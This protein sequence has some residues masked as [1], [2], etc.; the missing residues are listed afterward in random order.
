MNVCANSIQANQLF[1]ENENALIFYCA[2]ATQATRLLKENGLL[3][4]EIQFEVNLIVF[5]K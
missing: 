3:F 5:F 4:F 2:I 1:V